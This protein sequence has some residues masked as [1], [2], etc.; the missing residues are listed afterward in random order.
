MALELQK[1]LDCKD[2]YK[3]L[4]NL[5]SSSLEKLYD[6]PHASLAVFRE[7]PDLAKQYVMRLLLLDG[8]ISLSTVASW[9]NT[10]GHGQGSH[11]EAINKLQNLYIVSI[12][13]DD[14]TLNPV[15]RSSIRQQHGGRSVSA[16][17]PLLPDR[18]VRDV[19]FLTKYA[20]ERWE[21]LLHYLIDS[22]SS[23]AI[24]AGMQQLMKNSGLVTVKSSDGQALTSI[25]SLGF[26]FLL[27]NRRMQV[28]HILQEYIRNS[29]VGIVSNYN[30]RSPL[31]GCIVNE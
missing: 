30:K 27:L 14:I 17:E 25:S 29:E 2:L 6:S 21:C 4:T 10:T 19:N 28:W 26:Q 11:Q 31:I 24:S 18:H 5:G 1:K 8:A 9:A 20:D 12:V 7:L 3:F 22:S 15:F 13:N 16:L 23:Q